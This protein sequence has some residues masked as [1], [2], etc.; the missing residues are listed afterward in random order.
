MRGNSP[1]SIRSAEVEGDRLRVLYVWPMYLPQPLCI[2]VLQNV[3]LNM[4]ITNIA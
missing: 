3:E 4:K 1:L 2:V